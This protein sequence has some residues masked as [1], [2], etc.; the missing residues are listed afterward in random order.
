KRLAI[1]DTIQGFPE[2]FFEL[3]ALEELEFYSSQIRSFPEEIRKLRNLK[4][5][6]IM[7]LDFEKDAVP[8]DYDR[9]FTILAECP[10][11]V[12]VNLSKSGMKQIPPSINKL[13][14][15]KELEIGS[16][17]IKK[18]TPELCELTNLHL[19]NLEVNQIAE[20]PIEIRNLKNLR[21]LMLN[22]NHSPKIQV[23][24]LFAHIENF[25]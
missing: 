7:Q 23:Q 2:G 16:N 10:K 1:N 21:T 9:L 17:G 19:L 14:Q 18:I 22:S 5:I 25:Q 12:K 6:A 8:I 11:L 20:V 3:P 15:I 24:N 4:S 13:K